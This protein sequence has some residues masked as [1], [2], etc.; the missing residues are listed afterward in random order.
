MAKRGE[1]ANRNQTAR[2]AETKPQADA[3]NTVGRVIAA[4]DPLADEPS[5]TSTPSSPNA[6][7]SAGGSSTGGATVGATLPAETTRSANTFSP[8]GDTRSTGAPSA[9][10]EVAPADAARPPDSG[11]FPEKIESLH[12]AMPVAAGASPASEIPVNA[13]SSSAASG[14]SVG[15][16]E[17]SRPSGRAELPA[18]AGRE[19]GRFDEARAVHTPEGDGRP[20]G[21][22][23]A[24]T[25]RRPIPRWTLILAAIVAIFAI[26]SYFVVG[27]REEVVTTDTLP[28]PVGPQVDPPPVTSPTPATPAPPPEPATPAQPPT[29]VQ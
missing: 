17:D 21:G 4:A 13:S 27:D 28:Q 16:D 25:E 7:N 2:N 5:S 3:A 1:T 9:S 20:L 12:T 15:G 14:V 10:Q 24:S 6:R 26:I 11:P 29:P 8:A 18:P 22:P 23:L 19:P